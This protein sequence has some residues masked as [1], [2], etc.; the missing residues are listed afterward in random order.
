MS[1]ALH[2]VLDKTYGLPAEGEEYAR[3]NVQRETRQPAV[4]ALV[5][6]ARL[7]QSLA[8][9]RSLG[10]RGLRVAADRT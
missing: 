8:T 6:D 7:R 3:W 5:L 10:S 4:D 2:K 9:L 1:D